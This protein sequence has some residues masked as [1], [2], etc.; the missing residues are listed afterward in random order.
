MAS[1]CP[2]FLSCVKFYLGQV[3]CQYERKGMFG[4]LGEDWIDTYSVKYKDGHFQV[5]T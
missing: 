1:I 4:L 3:K 2:R 5:D